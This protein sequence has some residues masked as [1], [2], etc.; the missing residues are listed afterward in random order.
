VS[1]NAVDG[2]GPVNGFTGLAVGIGV[3]GP[4]ENATVVDNSSRFS[5]DPAGPSEGSWLALL[6]E[7]VGD[8]PTNFGSRLAFVPVGDHAVV[9]TGGSAFLAGAAAEHA[10]LSANTLVGGGVQPAC[11]VR[12]SGDLVA[13]G[14]QA[15]F[16][17]S[18]NQ[19]VG[20]RLTA[21]TITAATNRIRGT[22]SLLVLEVDPKR[23]A[24]VGNLA[25]G[26]T[27]IASPGGALANLPAPWE[28]LNPTV[29]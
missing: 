10:T 22:R 27:R 17:D 13:Q 7:S 15:T 28:P 25:A 19:P 12:I 2:V 20:V 5:A 11:L 3:F 21:A 1:G 6:V 23:L 26:G 18:E 16:A 4:F 29:P 9:F 24:A 8:K 14:N